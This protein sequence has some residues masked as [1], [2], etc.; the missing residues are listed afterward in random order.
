MEDNEKNFFDSIPVGQKIC[1]MIKQIHLFFEK[2]LNCR[3]AEYNI[4]AAQ[5]TILAHLKLNEDREIN[6][7]DIEKRF[8]LSKPTITGLLKRLNAKELVEI[9]ESKKDRRYRQIILSEKGEEYLK[10]AKDDLNYMYDMLCCGFS[11]E[12]LEKISDQLKKML[13]NLENPKNPENP[14]NIKENI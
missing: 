2:R 6:P 9:T 1:I 4:T 14:K 5:A 8:M 13:E 7:I 12:E 10:A 3:M 11:D